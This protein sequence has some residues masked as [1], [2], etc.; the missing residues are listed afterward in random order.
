MVLQTAIK[1]GQLT[2]R[3][4]NTSPKQPSA[5]RGLQRRGCC[6]TGGAFQPTHPKQNCCCS[7]FTPRPLR[8]C[9]FVGFWKTQKENK[10]QNKKLCSCSCLLSVFSLVALWHISFE[11]KNHVS[12]PLTCSFALSKC[13]GQQCSS[14]EEWEA[15][16]SV[17]VWA[18]VY[19]HTLIL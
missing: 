5:P 8:I 18:Y 1:R 11:G 12:P 10:K 3:L 19:P 13:L 6:G 16:D 7:R 4:C 17:T 9:D 14:Y 15:I 2:R